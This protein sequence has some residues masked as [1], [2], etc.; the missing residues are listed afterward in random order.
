MAAELINIPEKTWT[1]VASSVTG[2]VIKLP[3][4]EGDFKFFY[5]IRDAGEAAPVDDTDSGKYFRMFQRSRNEIIS[6]SNPIDVYIYGYNSDP[7]SSDVTK[8]LVDL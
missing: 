7:D 5:T 2:G 4:T 6:S 3:E 8:L 1:V